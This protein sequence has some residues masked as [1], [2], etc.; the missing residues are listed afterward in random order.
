VFSTRTRAYS[1]HSAG[2]LYSHER[3]LYSKRFSA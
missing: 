1:F 3:V 2:A